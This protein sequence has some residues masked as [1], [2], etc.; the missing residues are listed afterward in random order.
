MGDILIVDD[1]PPA[2]RRLQRLLQAHPVEVVAE[3][4]NVVEARQALT[5]HDEIDVIF[6][7]IRMPGPKGFSLLET[8]DVKASVVFVTAYDE[9]AVRAFEVHALDYL[10]KPI[11][12]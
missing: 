12:P 6:L 7:D 4:R 8:M 2:R 9:Y 1:E 5:R 10:L 11:D 3:A